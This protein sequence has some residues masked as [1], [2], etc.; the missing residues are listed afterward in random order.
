M[1]S[2]QYTVLELIERLQEEHA[3]VGNH[4]LVRVNFSPKADEVK[5]HI[6]AT[7]PPYIVIPISHE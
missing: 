7:S 3:K 4:P 6:P 1:K 2:Q 5:A